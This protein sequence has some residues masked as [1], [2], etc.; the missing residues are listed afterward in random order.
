MSDF[1]QIVPVAL[2]TRLTLKAGCVLI[3]DHG[4]R[5]L[6]DPGHFDT[7]ARLEEALWHTAAIGLCDIDMVYFTHLHFD[8]Y[9]DLGFADVPL[10]LMPRREK[11]AVDEFVALRGDLDA[12]ETRIRAAHHSIAPVFMRQFL[13]MASDP[14]YDFDHVS[15][16]QQL[17][18]IDA[19]KNITRNLKTVDLPGHSIGQLG[20]EMITRYGRT[21]VA[22]DAALSLE[23]YQQP[24]ISHHLV[25]VD[26]DQLMATRSR[27]AEFDCVAPG[28]GAWFNPRTGQ[29]ISTTQEECNA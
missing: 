22:G 12:Y 25:V 26:P 4:V 18:L 21:L 28:H 24:D 16:S 9:N 2:G 13:Y 17:C 27:L 10:V 14:R 7:R 1:V 15:F 5:V 23:D 6:V 20:L 3:N 11:I 19:D 29:P 8:H